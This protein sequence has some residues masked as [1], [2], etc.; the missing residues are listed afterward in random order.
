MLTEARKRACKRYRLRHPDRV[1]AK[2]RKY[3]DKNRQ[4]I[5][6]QQKEY[7]AKNAVKRRQYNQLYRKENPEKC[8]ETSRKTRESRYAQGKIR[9]ARSRAK[10]KNMEFSL[11]IDDIIARIHNNKCEVTGERC[12]ILSRY[13]TS[14]LDR[15]DSKKGYTL[16][17]VRVVIS[18]F[19]Y[20]RGE[21]S[22]EVFLDRCKKVVKALDKPKIPNPANDNRPL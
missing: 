2:N 9:N 15:I 6:E 18:W 16:D 4:K 12:E 5:R 14:S 11:P 21:A 17:N 13:Y 1:R 10:K 19:N 8:M 7:K 20:M 22:D 3:N